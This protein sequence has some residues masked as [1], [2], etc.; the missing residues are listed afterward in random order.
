[1]NKEILNTLWTF[2]F[3]FQLF[4]FLTQARLWLRKIRRCHKF[5]LKWKASNALIFPSVLQPVISETDV[6]S[7]SVWLRIVW[8]KHQT[9]TADTWNLSTHSVEDLSFILWYLTFHDS[10]LHLVNMIFIGLASPGA[11]PARGRQ[12][13]QTALYQKMCTCL[14]SISDVWMTFQNVSRDKKLPTPKKVFSGSEE[15]PIYPINFSLKVANCRS[16]GKNIKTK[17]SHYLLTRKDFWPWRTV[18]DITEDANLVFILQSSQPL[19]QAPAPAVRGA[20]QGHLAAHTP[21]TSGPALMCSCEED[22][23]G[24]RKAKLQ[25]EVVEIKSCSEKK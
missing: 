15:S 9:G 18:L 23:G 4:F 3:L 24:V 5:T 2:S 13:C 14:G 7:F 19:L 8:Q 16:L 25:W 1:M 12:W 21:G 6:T 10:V 17:E 11:V 20:G 22:S